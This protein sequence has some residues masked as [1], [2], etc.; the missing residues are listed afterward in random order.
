MMPDMSSLTGEGTQELI[1]ALQDYL[2]AENRKDQIA[3]D[4]AE[5]TYVAE[6]P[7]FDDTRS[8]AEP[9]EA[10]ARGDDPRGID[11]R[12]IDPRGGDE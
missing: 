8:N 12:G 10:G 2:D 3:Q 7:R 4:Q 9:R 1:W 6:D 11:P 5:G